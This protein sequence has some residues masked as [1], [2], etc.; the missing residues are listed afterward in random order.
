[1]RSVRTR[2]L[3]WLACLALALGFFGAGSARA[4]VVNGGFES[5]TFAGWTT[6][7]AVGVVGAAYPIPKP[8][9]SF[10][11]HISTGFAPEIPG[12]AGIPV[13]P[14]ALS[15]FVGVPVATLEALA[16][17]FGGFTA[18]EGSAIKQ[19]ITGVNPG[20]KISFSWDFLTNEVILPLDT[21][22]DFAFVVITPAG[23]TSL[24]ADTFF[25]TFP[26]A[27]LGSGY[28]RHT[29][30][31]TFGFTFST[32]GDF[33][34]AFGVADQGDRAFASGLLLDAV[35]LQAIPEPNTVAL[36]GLGVTGLTG[37]SF[38]RRQKRGA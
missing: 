3:R 36:L 1:M 19:T 18:G 38:Y 6:T 31:Q 28:T 13:T 26:F 15:T 37:Y 17:G 22:N 9:G 7:G 14:V 4:E 20:D 32:T 27:P 35:V 29:G 12:I 10:M 5:G 33:V 24:L 2:H 16:P 11:A 34:V 25:G 23:T 30:F 8:E 21:F